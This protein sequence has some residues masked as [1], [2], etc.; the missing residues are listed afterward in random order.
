MATNYDDVLRQFREAGLLVD[1][2]ETGKLRRCKVEGDREKR[3]WYVAHELRLD[4]GD[5]VIVGQFGVWQGADNGA[6]KIE[7]G[8]TTQLT[9]EQKAAF[10]QRLA[11]D[12]KRAAAARK[13]E[14]QRAARRADVAWRKCS[15]AGECAYLGRKGVQPYGVRFSPQ[16]NLVIPIL[17]VAGSIHGLQVIYGDTEAKKRKGRDKDYWPA[18]L[19]KQGHFFLIGAPHGG[20]TLLVCEGYA[21]GASLHEAMG[22]PVAVAFDANNLLPV[23]TALH[24]RYRGARILVCADDDFA[25]FGNPGVSSGSAAALAVGGAWVAPTFSEDSL[26]AAVAEAVAVDPVPQNNAEWKDRVAPVLN[27]RSKLTDFNDLHQAEGLH[28]ARA[29]VEA[30]LQEL[31]WA[32][33]TPPARRAQ[34]KGG[35]EKQT[36]MPSM[37]SVEDA[38]ARYWGTYGLGGKALFDVIVRRIVHR[39]DVMN[40][41]PPRAWDMIKGHPRWRVVRDT[42]IGFDPTEKDPQIKANL[43]GG[44]PTVPKAGKCDRLLELL[45]YL[46]GNEENSRDIYRWIL[47]WLAYPIQNRGAKM[48]SAIVVHGPQGTGKSRFFEAYAEIFGPYG[49]VLGQE[50]LEDKFNA[51]WAEKKLF[52]LADEVLARTDMYHIKNRLKGFITGG[53]IRVNP[54]NVAAHNEKNQMNIVFLS[55]ERQPLVLEDDDRRHCVIWVPPKLDETYFAEVNDEIENGGVAALHHYLLNLDLGD[56]KPWTKPPMTRAKQDLVELGRSS[57]ERFIREWIA[58]EVH[59][60]NGNPLPFCPCLGSHLYQAYAKWCET[61]GERKR[62][63]KD[64]VSLVGKM[65]GWMAGGSVYTWASLT[66]TKARNRKMVIPSDAA[67]AASA[68]ARPEQSV[69]L[70]EKYKSRAEW[71]TACHFTFEAAIAC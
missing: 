31:G 60:A 54:K 37:L 14:Q 2:I 68:K 17:D 12:R 39:E 21:T 70:P 64:V 22:L 66:D 16:G 1:V 69:H 27:G 30:K 35:G 9:A 40:L 47:K 29:Q 43:F 23:A 67:M 42:E 38:V 3:G 46:C 62:A 28:L 10:K 34:P 5:Y 20:G 52:I 18:G 49:R 55:N 24:K 25:S 48:H 41:L 6:Q 63:M 11:E 32:E 8:K 44:W 57:E 50:A 51:D 59:D 15:P 45:E 65:P 13:A 7:L 53:T 26:R 4:S 33:S 61:H 19:A 58:G 36:A 71:L 56:F